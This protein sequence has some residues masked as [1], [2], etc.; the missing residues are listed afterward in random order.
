MLL[1]VTVPLITSSWRTSPTEEIVQEIEKTV[2]AAHL[3]AL[4]T[5]EARRLKL[6]ESGLLGGDGIPATQLPKGWKLQLMRFTENRFRKPQR[7]EYW[8]FNGAGICDPLT[9]R[10]AN[11]D[12]SLIL[13]FDPLTASILTDEN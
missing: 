7:D 10:I 5:G 3:K 9:L 8:E 11:K 13:K 4:E 12:E 6:E 2:Q 1:G